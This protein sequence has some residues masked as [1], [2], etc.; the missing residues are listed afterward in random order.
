MCDRLCRA[1][2]A[3]MNFRQKHKVFRRAS[4]QVQNCT[5]ETCKGKIRFSRQPKSRKWKLITLEDHSESCVRDQKNV[6][7]VVGP[8]YPADILARALEEEYKNDN[9]LSP[10][11]VGKSLKE[12][13]I[14][15]NIPE[16]FHCLEV[17][18]VLHKKFKKMKD[19]DD[20][21]DKGQ[22]TSKRSK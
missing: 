5:N 19:D 22:P 1:Y 13:R 16:D 10:E 7:S 18:D 21:V 3:G 12:K 8:A 6:D 4:M 11:R 20:N 15:R 14:Y 2:A 9:N 17:H